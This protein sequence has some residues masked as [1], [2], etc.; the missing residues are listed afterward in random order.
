MAT[1]T[2][3]NGKPDTSDSHKPT[4]EQAMAAA[5]VTMAPIPWCSD[6][7]A[8]LEWKISNRPNAY[9]ED[10]IVM[11][12]ETARDA[13]ANYRAWVRKTFVIDLGIAGRTIRD[14]DEVNPKPRPDLELKRWM[15]RLL[16]CEW[17]SRLAP[18]LNQLRGDECS[19]RDHTS[20][21]HLRDGERII[22]VTPRKVVVKA[23]DGEPRDID[24]L[25]LVEGHRGS[26]KKYV[27]EQ[28]TL[29]PLRRLIERTEESFAKRKYADAHPNSGIIVDER[30]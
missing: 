29:T 16:D 25:K 22:E 4:V 5:A 18:D 17:G 19:L 23:D 7:L 27:Y 26:Q 1:K 28:T 12:A 9:S 14:V 2:N 10:L 20:C 15:H 24:R 13:V 11:I 3:G 21:Q 6:V 30:E 8:E